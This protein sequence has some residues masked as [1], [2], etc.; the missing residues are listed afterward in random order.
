MNPQ[1]ELDGTDQEILTLLQLDA[2]RTIADIAERVSMSPPAVKRRIARLEA[3]GVITGYTTVI[4]HTKLGTPVQAFIELR[5]VGN[6]KVTDIAGVAT[7][8]P[9]VESIFTIAG[10]PDALVAVRVRDVTHLVS[11]I[12]QL[13]RTGRVTGTK[14][15]IVLDARSGR[16]LHDPERVRGGD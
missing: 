12:D 2:R 16:G 9:E 14:T 4:D 11:V 3:L 1:D 5:F 10:D 8:L 15:L 7:G 13:R 6:T